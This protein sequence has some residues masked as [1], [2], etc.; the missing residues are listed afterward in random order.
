M[1]NF[2]PSDSFVTRVMNNVRAY[3]AG[4][5]NQSRRGSAFVLSSP[6]FSILYAGGL[7]LGMLNII[8]MALILI[9]PAI[10]Q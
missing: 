2:R 9:S 4:I 8:R 7:L 1:S 10:C 3:E 6:V 5:A